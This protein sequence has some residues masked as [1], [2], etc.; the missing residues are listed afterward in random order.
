MSAALE[1]NIGVTLAEGFGLDAE[2][3]IEADETTVVVGPN[4]AGKTTLLRA[5]A[6][7]RPIDK[8]YIRVDGVVLDDPDER[9]FLAPE[10]R[11]IGMVFQDGLLFP[12]LD[13]RANIAF[14]LRARGAKKSDAERVASDWLARV[15]LTQVAQRK[16][17]ALSGGEAQRVALARALA[18]APR[19]LLLDE[20]L[21]ALD[22]VTRVDMRRTLRDHLGAYHGVRV[23]VTHDPLE[24]LTLGDRIVVLE[25]GRVTQTGTPDEIRAR[26]ASAYVALLLGT[27]VV[28]GACESTEVFRT[29]AG[30]ALSIAIDQ[31]VEGAAVAVVEPSAITLFT[32]QPHMSARNTWETVVTDVDHEPARVRVR[33][34]APT[35]L[36]ADVTHAAAAEL[37]L[38]PGAR[39]WCAVKATAIA[40]HPR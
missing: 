2:F 23:M 21:S 25:D 12:T 38:E 22:A 8:G 30:V 3:A 31:I 14:G 40:V 29:E 19:V 7:L 37:S 39:V 32:E 13:A 9:V 35:P 15:G 34:G 10:Q 28:R 26:P 24:A 17:R 33:L 4:G 18:P 20:P 27:N 16:P 5:L 1:A 11:P 36:L 6:G